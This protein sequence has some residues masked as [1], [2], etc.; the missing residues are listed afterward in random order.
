[1]AS[2]HAAG[3]YAGDGL[4]EQL[5]ALRQAHTTLQQRS[6]AAATEA[7]TTVAEARARADDASTHQ[8]VQHVCSPSRTFVRR[9]THHISSGAQLA[10]RC[11]AA[12]DDQSCIA[13]IHA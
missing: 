12:R 8:G 3:G 9:Q 2:A 6:T 13:R 11:P 10:D 5:E 7:E 1:M 4:K